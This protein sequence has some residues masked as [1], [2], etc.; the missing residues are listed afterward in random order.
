VAA[1]AMAAMAALLATVIVGVVSVGIAF[2]ARS[3]AVAGADAA[4][5]A[6]AVATY[7]AAANTAPGQLAA[8]VARANGAELVFCSCRVDASLEARVVVV[9]VEVP[10]DVPIFGNLSIR[11]GAR[12]EFDPRR[13]L[14]R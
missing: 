14:G 1:I 11:V 13:W 2:A 5:L 10:V 6:A 3:Q 4:A 9:I 7:P 8:S 12:A